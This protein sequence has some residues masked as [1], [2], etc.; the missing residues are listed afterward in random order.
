RT[1]APETSAARAAPFALLY[2]GLVATVFCWGLLPLFQKRLLAV[3]DPFEATFF[4]FFLSGLLLLAIVLATV[5]HGLKKALRCHPGRLLATS[6]LGP[7]LAMVAFNFGLQAVA[8]GVASLIMALQPIL[9]Y[10]LAVAIG[11]E[12]GSRARTLS[13][14]LSLGGLV[15]VVAAE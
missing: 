6:L 13:L 8:T 1:T 2:V 10:L 4:R 7:A 12:K 11:Q 5:P 3:F 15:L 14:L 9:T